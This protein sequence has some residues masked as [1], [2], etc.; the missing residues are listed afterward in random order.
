MIIFVHNPK[1]AGTSIREILLRQINFINPWIDYT[2][3]WDR[4]NLQGA[5]IRHD[6]DFICGH[7]HAKSFMETFPD[8]FIFTWMRCPTERISSLYNHITQKPNADGNPQSQVVIDQR[9]CFDD[10]IDLEWTWNYSMN[11]LGGTNPESFSHIGFCDKF[12][13][14]LCDLS[15]KIG[16]PRNFLKPIVEN[17]SCSEFSLT[18]DQISRIL[19]KNDEEYAFY[20]TARKLFVH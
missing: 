12:E 1:C 19:S 3:T 14:S 6:A 11:F 9:I 18:A 10:F 13:H 2:C 15:Q 17:K 20:K 5:D 7:I 4:Y 16:F 8:N